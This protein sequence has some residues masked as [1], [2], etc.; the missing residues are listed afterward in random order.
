M[1]FTRARDLLTAGLIGFGVGYLLFDQAYHAMPDLPTLAGGTLL[2]L[3]LIELG[4][5]ASARN[6]I[7][8][9]RVVYDAILIARFAVLAKASSLLGA[10]MV[11]GWLAGIAYLAPRAG[12][13]A[14]AGDDLPAAVVGAICAA[15]LI[16]AALWLEHC[17]RAPGMDDRD[18]SRDP[19]A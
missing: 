1:R 9:G 7:A 8:S 11:G 18:E 4:F 6:R 2:V 3:A 10:I 14:A 19:H 16:G 17:C 12:T 13:I 15:C 5:A